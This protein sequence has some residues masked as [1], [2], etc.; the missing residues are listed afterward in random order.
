MHNNLLK[1]MDI[2]DRMEDMSYGG[3]TSWTS[4]CIQHFPHLERFYGL[5][6]F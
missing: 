5:W 6:S 3:E 1:L 4:V 2:Y